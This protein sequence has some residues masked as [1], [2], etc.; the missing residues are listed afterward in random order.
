MDFAPPLFS[1]D[2]A[3]EEPAGKH[4]DG[5]RLN[6]KRFTSYMI[7]GLTYLRKQL[8]GP[9]AMNY[10]LET[11][12]LSETTPIGPAVAQRQFW[13]TVNPQLFV[14]TQAAFNSGYGGL[15]QGQ[16]LSQPL[17]DPYNN[18]FGNIV[19]PQG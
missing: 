9:G 12:A 10:A 5:H 16:F 15:A 19:G 18:Q 4:S 11:L 8:P 13:K 1:F 7:E 14:P 3:T 6:S 17:F 2:T